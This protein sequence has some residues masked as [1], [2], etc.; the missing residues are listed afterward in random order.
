MTRDT[1]I[2][3]RKSLDKGYK[4]DLK[5]LDVYS[6]YGRLLKKQKPRKE[7]TGDHVCLE[8]TDV[9]VVKDENG[10]N[11]VETKIIPRKIAISNIIGVFLGMDVIDNICVPKDGNSS[12]Y[13]P[14]NLLWL[15]KKS[16]ASFMMKKN[17][18]KFSKLTFSDV[19]EIRTAILKGSSITLKSLAEKYNVSE[20]T[21]SSLRC[22]NKKN[23]WTECEIDRKWKGRNQML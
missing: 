20:N 13:H 2:F 6:P 12:N 14:G 18:E 8:I 21:I 22:K 3:I 23:R 17:R 1:Y 9:K 4:L 19:K 5:T 15:D 16:A 11:K 10:Q 7:N